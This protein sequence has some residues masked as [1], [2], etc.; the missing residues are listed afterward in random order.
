MIGTQLPL[1]GMVAAIVAHAF[2]DMLTA[3]MI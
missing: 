1:N 2:A 3:S